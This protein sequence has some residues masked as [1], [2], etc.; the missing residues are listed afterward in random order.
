M[1]CRMPTRQDSAVL[2]LFVG[3]VQSVRT[4]G[5]LSNMASNLDISNTFDLTF[6]LRNNIIKII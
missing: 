5:P 6:L 3:T 4:A 1:K 2:I